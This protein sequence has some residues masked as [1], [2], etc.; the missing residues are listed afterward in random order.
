[1]GVDIN[2]D[3]IAYAQKNYSG[4]FIAAD[5]T[6]F[7]ITETFDLILLNSLLHHIDDDGVVSLLRSIP[8]FMHSKSEVH[9]LD[10]EMPDRMGI[11]RLLAKSDRGN[12]VRTRKAWES[13]FKGHFK[14][15]GLTPYSVSIAGIGLWNMLH[16]RGELK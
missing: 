10:L 5:V 7:E 12:Y 9:I 1:M 11:P 2:P 15:N 13:I 4:N 14:K 6:Q 3:Y 8:R 16:F